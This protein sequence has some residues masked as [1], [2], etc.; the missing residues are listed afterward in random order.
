[1]T[2]Q[3]VVLTLG[4]TINLG[5]F[6]NAKIEIQGEC[7]T[8]ADVAELKAYLGEIIESLGGDEITTELFARWQRRVLGGA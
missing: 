8:A 3:G 4:G 6:E 5:N 1:M 2:V 7:R